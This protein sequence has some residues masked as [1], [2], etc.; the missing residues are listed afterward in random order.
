[1]Y[2]ASIFTFPVLGH[3]SLDGHCSSLRRLDCGATLYWNLVAG[4]GF[5]TCLKTA[6]LATVE[7]LWQ[8]VLCL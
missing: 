4:Q 6:F 7:A 5:Y 1:M 3:L 8:V 2:T